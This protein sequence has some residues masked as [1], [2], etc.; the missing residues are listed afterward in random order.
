MLTGRREKKDIER[1]LELGV[2][3]YIVKPLDPMLLVQKVA[4]LLTR[5]PAK[6]PDEVNFAQGKV[7]L[8][9]TASVEITLVALSEVGIVFQ[10]PQHFVEGTRLELECEVFRTIQI[11]APFLR[12]QSS[13]QKGGFWETRLIFVGAEERVLTKI[14]DWVQSNAATAARKAG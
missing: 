12:V 5:R 11:E 13:V 1:A 14:R 7:T 2:H 9:A 6:E 10:S 8:L 3:D 4:D